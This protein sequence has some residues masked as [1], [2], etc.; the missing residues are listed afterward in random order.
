MADAVIE[1][2]QLDA[3]IA[4]QKLQEAKEKIES[5][6]E[7]FSNVKSFKRNDDFWQIT[8]EKNDGFANTY[9]VDKML[10]SVKDSFTDLTFILAQLFAKE[11]HL[12]GY[13]IK[14]KREMYYISFEFTSNFNDFEC[15]S[16][17]EDIPFKEEY[18][19]NLNGNVYGKYLTLNNIYFK[20]L[21]IEKYILENIDFI[22]G[23]YKTSQLGLF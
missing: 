9:K 22:S 21:E 14:E 4:K 11:I 12:V 1:K 17:T 2:E 16:K 15:T 3:Y 6:K 13:Q 10:S 20:V 19:D 5:G 7:N 8:I 18:L 23:F